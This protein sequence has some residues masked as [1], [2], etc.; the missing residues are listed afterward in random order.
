MTE[1]QIGTS[2]QLYEQGLSS[3]TIGKRLGFDNHTVLKALRARGVKI[4]PA[5]APNRRAKNQ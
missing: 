4:R 3:V 1:T 2:V 5:V